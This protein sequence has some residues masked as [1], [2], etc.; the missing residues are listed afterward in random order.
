MSSG[1]QAALSLYH[2]FLVD[3]L[4]RS[5]SAIGRQAVPKAGYMP[6]LSGSAP[7][8]RRAQPLCRWPHFTGAPLEA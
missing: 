7:R 8:A 3:W 2:R 5:L 4:T 1:S 6:G